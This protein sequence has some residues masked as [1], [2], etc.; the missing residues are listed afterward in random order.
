LYYAK[1]KSCRKVF[2]I[3]WKDIMPGVPIPVPFGVDHPNIKTFLSNYETR[4][5]PD[6]K[7]EK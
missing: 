2:V 4:K 6:Y 3:F 5:D 7:I 1:C